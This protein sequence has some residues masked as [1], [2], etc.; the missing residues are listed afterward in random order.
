MT[1]EQQQF[2]RVPVQ[3]VDAIEDLTKLIHAEAASGILTNRILIAN[4]VVTLKI[5]DHKKAVA[6]HARQKSLF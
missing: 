2:V 3:L 6:R 1:D 4:N 5:N